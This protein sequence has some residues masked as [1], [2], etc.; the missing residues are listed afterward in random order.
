MRSNCYWKL[1]QQIDKMKQTLTT[2]SGLE[3][4]ENLVN[5]IND[6][7]QALNQNTQNDSTLSGKVNELEAGLNQNTQND[8]EIRDRVTTLEIENENGTLSDDDI[9]SLFNP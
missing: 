1:K 5:K 8:V 9:Q 4:G 7:E 6:L 3:E 2:I